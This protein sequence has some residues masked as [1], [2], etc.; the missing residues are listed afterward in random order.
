MSHLRVEL[1]AEERPLL[2]LERGNGRVGARGGHSVAGRRHVHVVPVTHPH[3]G[4]LARAK[5]AKQPSRFYPNIR[6]SVLSPVGAGDVAAGKM[7]EQLHTVA[8]AQNRSVQLQQFGIG[9]GN[10]FSIYRIRPARENDALGLPVSDPLDRSGGRVDLAVDV[11]LP[12]PPGN[13]LGVL[14]PEVDYQNTIVMRLHASALSG[15]DP[16]K[17]SSRHRAPAQLFTTKDYSPSS[18]TWKVGYLRVLP[19]TS[20]PSC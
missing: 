13:Q 17:G 16:L 6:A 10:A 2:V 18:S 12:H 4:L 3:R 11:S 19:V 14:G 1:H 20:C 9:G 7:R 5:P 8:E 15:C